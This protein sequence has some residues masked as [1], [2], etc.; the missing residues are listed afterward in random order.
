[1]WKGYTN[2]QLLCDG[3]PSSPRVSIP[4]ELWV[5]GQAR[6]G[7]VIQRVRIPR[8]SRQGVA[9]RT[10]GACCNCCERH[11]SYTVLGEHVEPDKRLNGSR[12]LVRDFMKP[13]RGF[14]CTDPFRKETAH[15]RYSPPCD[16]QAR[17]Y[18][19]WLCAMIRA[20]ES[21]WKILYS[22]RSSSTRE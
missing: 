9:H 11:L 22:E 12:I 5:K 1:M 14:S 16:D 6:Q 17:V 10:N 13:G 18:R 7:R 21:F 20:V 2:L 4:G 8:K 3:Y 15:K 19:V